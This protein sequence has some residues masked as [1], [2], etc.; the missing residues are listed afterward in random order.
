MPH[1]GD[2]LPIVALDP[3]QR[4]LD[5]VSPISNFKPATSVLPSS[6]DA[7]VISQAHCAS[8]ACRDLNYVSPRADIQL[9]VSV[10]SY[11]HYGTIGLES[12]RV[13][14]I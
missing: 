11:S 8:P 10:V 2:S 1:I 3:A 5:D 7:A 13:T 12:H 6:N 4:Q 9:P 14:S